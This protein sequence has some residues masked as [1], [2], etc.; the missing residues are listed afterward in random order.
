MTEYDVTLDDETRQV[1]HQSLRIPEHCDDELLD[2]YYTSGVALIADAINH[3][4]VNFQLLRKQPQY[5]HALILYVEFC[6]MERGKTAPTP[7]EL[8]PI[9]W[10]YIRQLQG[11]FWGK[12]YENLEQ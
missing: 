2:L 8:P 10:L 5:K 6:Y 4:H 9:F 12:D 3:E 11:K 7:D 1:L